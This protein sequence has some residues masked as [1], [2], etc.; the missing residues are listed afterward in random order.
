VWLGLRRT[1]ALAEIIGLPRASVA[2]SP[3]QSGKSGWTRNGQTREEAGALLWQSAC[4]MERLAGCM[5]GLPVV[6]KIYS[7]PTDR[8]VFVGTQLVPQAYFCRLADIAGRIP[9]L[10]DLY[11]KGRP[12]LEICD[13]VLDIDREFQELASL[14]PRSWWEVQP[15]QER[16]TLDLVFQ[17]FHQYFTARAHLQL[18]LYND[19]SNTFAYSHTICTEACRSVAERY[20]TLRP[21]VLGGFFPVRLFDLQAVTAAVFLLH[22]VYCPGG[23]RGIE[24][25]RTPPSGVLI[26]QIVRSMESA[27]EGVAGQFAREAART[28]RSL[29]AMLSSNP[30]T[31]SR[32]VSLRV[33]LLGRIH[34]KYQDAQPRPSEPRAGSSAT[35]P[36]TYGSRDAASMPHLQSDGAANLTPLSVMANDPASWSMGISEVLP[37]LTDDAYAAD[38]WLMLGDFDTGGFSFE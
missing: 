37:F 34:V 14:A 35:L 1:I 33:P 17:Y 26:Q 15:H 28:I 20:T 23:S 21:L 24:A 19:G 9:A 16:I 18:A 25:A 32:Y 8:P 13:K 31:N 6:T 27:S 5:F 4:I 11:A 12:P 2:P 7:L 30:T 22:S 29:S 36:R 10:D 3:D 38:Q